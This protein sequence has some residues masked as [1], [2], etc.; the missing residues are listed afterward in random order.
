MRSEHI[1][2]NVASASS[3]RPAWGELD[4]PGKHRDPFKVE[5]KERR[6]V[7]PKTKKRISLIFPRNHI[8]DADFRA[9]FGCTEN[10]RKSQRRLATAHAFEV[11]KP[12]AARDSQATNCSF[13]RVCIQWE[14]REM[15]GEV[16]AQR[17]SRRRRHRLDGQP[18]GRVAHWSGLRRGD[19]FKFKSI[20]GIIA[21]KLNDEHFNHLHI[22]VR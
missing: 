11:E 20:L 6:R 5:I 8:D 2:R 15:G 14:D 1:D 17:L 13:D 9:V 7:C 12:K 19:E 3:D 16:E 10:G 4:S 22:N 21:D 18:A